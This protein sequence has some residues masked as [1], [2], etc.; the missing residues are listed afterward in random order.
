MALCSMSRTTVRIP[1]TYGLDFEDGTIKSEY[2]VEPG[3]TTML[4]FV[5]SNF[6]NGADTVDVNITSMAPES[7]TAFGALLLLLLAQVHLRF[8]LSM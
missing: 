8:I 5:I 3:E 2:G 7:W 6:G 4:Q 1:Q